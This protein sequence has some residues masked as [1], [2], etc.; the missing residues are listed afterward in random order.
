M[1]ALLSRS[2]ALYVE[3]KQLY[4]SNYYRKE[5]FNHIFYF[6]QHADSYS[7]DNVKYY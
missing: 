5:R 2:H 1:V 6:V 3:T 7:I 4:Q